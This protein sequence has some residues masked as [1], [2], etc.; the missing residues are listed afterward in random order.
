M[1]AVN[2]KPIP[3]GMGDFASRVEAAQKAMAEAVTKAGLQPDPFRFPLE[4]LA[5]TVGLFSELIQHL[6]AARQPVRDEELRKAVTRGVAD[7]ATETVRA[8]NVRNAVLGA[9]LLMAALLIGAVGGY[10]FHGSAPVVVG[11]SAGAEQC[12]DQNG[13]RLCWIPLWERL[14]SPR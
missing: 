3:S 6:E 1:A 14:P 7:C 13:G 5:M 9:G 10:L 4:S 8:L 2:P 12:Q 11:V